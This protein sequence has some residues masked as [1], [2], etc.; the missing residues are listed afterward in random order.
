M[1]SNPNPQSDDYYKVLG[2]HRSADDSQLKKAYRKLAIKYHPD[3]NPDDKRAE[4]YFK[5]VAERVDALSDPQK[6]A[7]YDRF[8]KDGAKAAEQG[9]DMGGMGQG[10]G[11]FPG[12]SRG[13]QMDGRRAQEVFSMFFGGDDP[14]ASFGMGGFDGGPGNIRVSVQHGPA[15][16][17]AHVLDGEQRRLHG[18]AGRQVQPKQTARYDVLPMGAK[19]VLVGLQAAAEKNDEVGVVERFDAAKGR[20]N[21]RLDEGGEVLALKE[22]N[23]QQMLSGVRLT[24]LTENP[25]MDGKSGTLVATRARGRVAALRG[26][27]LRDAEDR[28]HQRREPP[29]ARGALV[30]VAGVQAKP[31]LNGRKGTVQSWDGAA[32]R[33]RPSRSRPRTSLKL[34]PANVLL[35]APAV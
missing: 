30:T 25:D 6:R 32:K 14:F 21:V 17:R 34:K 1:S 15:R 26:G 24:G 35:C 16:R 13:P 9:Q 20:Y 11:G 22:A 3:K 31:E 28:V 5:A 8:G 12:G 23:L 7:G 19:V 33:R 29:A 2:V 10:F 18:R 4:E 27:A